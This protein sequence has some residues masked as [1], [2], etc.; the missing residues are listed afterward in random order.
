MYLLTMY[1]EKNLRVPRE[2]EGGVWALECAEAIV[3]GSGGLG[4]L[5]G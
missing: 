4:G 5:V 3:E 2:V 1:V